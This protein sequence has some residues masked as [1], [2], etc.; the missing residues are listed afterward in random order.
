M[1]CFLISYSL[2]CVRRLLAFLGREKSPEVGRI[3]RGSMSVIPSMVLGRNWMNI[4]VFGIW[5]SGLGYYCHY[6][7][8]INIGWK[9]MS[10]AWR[11]VCVGVCVVHYS[12]CVFVAE[13]KER[14]FFLSTDSCQGLYQGFGFSYSLIQSHL[15]LHSHYVKLRL[16][17]LPNLLESPGRVLG[18]RCG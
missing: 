1:T 14:N 6:K 16:A 7:C 10:V 13:M 3:L 9:G 4:Y 11:S 15:I 5:L 12:K 17:R 8:V 2:D 18:N